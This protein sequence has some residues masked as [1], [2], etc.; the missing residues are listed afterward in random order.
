MKG[1]ILIFLC[2]VGSAIAT[3]VLY[4]KYASKED[5]TDEDRRD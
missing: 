2:F 5:D 4:D 1:I 3:K